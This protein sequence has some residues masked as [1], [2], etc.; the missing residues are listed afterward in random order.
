MVRL[1]ICNCWICFYSICFYQSL[2]DILFRST[3]VFILSELSLCSP[4]NLP[5]SGSP[6][7][8][9]GHF[10]FSLWNLKSDVIFFGLPNKLTVFWNISFF[11]SV[12]QGLHLNQNWTFKP[13]FNQDL[14]QSTWNLGLWFGTQSVLSRVLILTKKIQ[15]MLNFMT[16]QFTILFIWVILMNFFSYFVANIKKAFSHLLPLRQA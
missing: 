10:E 1:L 13:L 2:F 11:I 7:L 4:R 12:P 8:L 16:P 5:C 15:L 14:P 6:L 9:P 3:L